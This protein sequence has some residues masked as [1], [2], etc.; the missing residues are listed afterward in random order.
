MNYLNHSKIAST[1]STSSIF[2][3]ETKGNYLNNR[4]SENDDFITLSC[5]RCLSIFIIKL[6]ILDQMNSYDTLS[7]IKSDR[8]PPP[9]IFVYHF[10][11]FLVNKS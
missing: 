3:D 5:N 8:A 1:S 4:R 9:G 6:Y 7:S 10:L 11:K 2:C